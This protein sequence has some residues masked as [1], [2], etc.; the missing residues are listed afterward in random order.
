MTLTVVSY[1]PNISSIPLKQ[2][3]NVRYTNFEGGM[4]MKSG[5]ADNTSNFSQG[6]TLFT[7]SANSFQ[8]LYDDYKSKNC[9][10]G[11]IRVDNSLTNPNVMSKSKTYI[12]D[13]KNNNENNNENT[14]SRSNHTIHNRS[15]N[16][17]FDIL[18]EQGKCLLNGK[19]NNI[20]TSQEM[21][22]RKKN[23]T[24]GSASSVVKSNI[25][26]KLSFSAVDSDTNK[27]YTNHLEVSN[28]K[29][30]TRNSGYIVPPKCRGKGNGSTPPFNSKNCGN[31]GWAV[32]TLLGK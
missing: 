28:A 24:I 10:T 18:S 13:S 27:I 32:S 31:P 6:R 23:K 14:W 3:S 20:M 4:P 25:N 5:F 17:S 29:R 2:Y 12:C 21:I 9:N 30:R 1:T 8:Y 11:V 15:R 16:M 7:K 19:Q 22:E 26:K